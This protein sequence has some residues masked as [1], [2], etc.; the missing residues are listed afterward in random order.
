[1]QTI[2]GIHVEETAKGIMKG[3]ANKRICRK[4]FRHVASSYPEEAILQYGLHYHV[5]L[6]PLSLHGYE[7]QQNRKVSSFSFLGANPLHVVYVVNIC[8]KA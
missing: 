4:P 1:M 3:K 6:F 2:Y 7:I 8:L 5:F